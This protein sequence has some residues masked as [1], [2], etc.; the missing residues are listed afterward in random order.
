MIKIKNPSRLLE[1]IK[2]P[3]YKTRLR[4]ETRTSR[5]VIDNIL[6]QLPNKVWKKGGLFLDPCCGRGTFLLAIVDRLLP[7]HSPN[8]VS[9]MIYGVDID[10]WCVYTTKIIV[11]DYLGVNTTNI[12]VDDSLIRKWNMKFDAVVGN[13][14]YQN[15]TNLIR[16][17]GRGNTSIWDKFVVKGLELLN[18]KGHLAFIHPAHWRKPEDRHGFWKLLTQ[19]NQ[20]IKLVM[21]SGLGDQDWF[22]IGFGVDYYVLQKTPKY[23]TTKVIDW[24]GIEYDLDLSTLPWLPNFAI[25]EITQLLGSGVNVLYNTFYHTQKDHSEVKTAKYL[26][27]VVHTINSDG[28][29]I[30]YFDSR[31]PNDDTHFGIPKVLLNQGRYQYPV[32]DYRGEYGMSQLTFGIPIKNKK[33]G[34]QLVDYINSPA[35]KRLIAATKWNTFYTDYGMFKSFRPDFYK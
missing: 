21:G 22:G 23:T 26:Y 7:Y 31:P 27:P 29:G 35:G 2:T 1:L 32:N 16:A 4:G 17:G 15:A 18:D 28:L 14:P 8:A 11:D 20:M 6:D 13:P 3:K 33:D 34:E 25:K 10:P 9:K 19:D 24:E 12:V 30:K 5:V